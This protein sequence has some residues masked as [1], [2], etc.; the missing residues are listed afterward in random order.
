MCAR[1]RPSHMRCSSHRLLLCCC[2][3]HLCPA[4]ATPPACTQLE[5]RHNTATVV[6]VR[7]SG[8]SRVGRWVR[9]WHRTGRLPDASTLAASA[10]CV[11]VPCM[12]VNQAEIDQSEWLECLFS[13]KVP[14]HHWQPLALAGRKQPASCDLCLLHTARCR[15]C[16][17]YTQPGRPTRQI[18]TRAIVPGLCRIK[19]CHGCAE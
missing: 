8:G 4:Y 3:R 13:A 7:S 9:P 17:V 5:E 11:C 19:L 14:L 12:Q 16:F 6:Q 1:A 2:R 10:M 15:C 18:W